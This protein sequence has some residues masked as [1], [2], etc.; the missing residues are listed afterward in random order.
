MTYLSAIAGPR[1]IFQTQAEISF[2]AIGKEN[3]E[4]Q[5]SLKHPHSMQNLL[6]KSFF[7]NSSPC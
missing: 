2:F 4:R 7:L 5:E 1:D 6:K 3:K